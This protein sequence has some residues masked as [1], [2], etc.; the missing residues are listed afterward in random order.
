M[1]T[2]YESK[3]ACNPRHENCIFWETEHLIE[4]VQLMI[5]RL[6]ILYMHTFQDLILR[7]VASHPILIIEPQSEIQNI[8]QNH[9]CNSKLVNK[10]EVNVLRM[11]NAVNRSFD[12]HQFCFHLFLSMSIPFPPKLPDSSRNAFITRI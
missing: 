6:R 3:V 5:F 10:T 2:S 1:G 9:E 12:T 4:F 8:H 7:R 11:G